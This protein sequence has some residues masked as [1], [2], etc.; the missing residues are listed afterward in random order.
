MLYAYDHHGKLCSLY[1]LSRKQIEQIRRQVTYY[2]PTCKE[3]LQI[4]SGLHHIPHFAHFST[5]QCKRKS[6]GESDE[7]ES[8][9]WLLFKWLKDQGYKVEMEYFIKEINQ[10]PDL[11][12]ISRDKR[13]I[14]IELQCST[15]SPDIIEKRTNSYYEA[16]IFPLWIVGS[17]HFRQKGKHQLLHTTFHRSLL[18]YFHHSYCMYYLNV[19]AQSVIIVDHILG[20][21]HSNCFA[22]S[23]A[24][25]LD[26]IT[27]PQLF[28]PASPSVTSYLYFWEKYLFK[29]RTIYQKSVGTEERQWR[30]FLYLKGKHFS[31][32][33]SVCC[34]PVPSQSIYSVK[35][36][37]WQTKFVLNH[38]ID[39]PVGSLIKLGHRDKCLTINRYQADPVQE[40]LQLLEQM[41]Y[42]RKSPKGN[43]IKRKEIT[44][45][46]HITQALEED[47]L[48]MNV[49]KNMVPRHNN[50]S[51]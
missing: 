50:V 29:L 3:P 48:V 35:V 36:Y 32:I 8:G 46:T 33:P 9:K 47:K 26:S 41:G 39:R 14:A 5:S 24:Y 2:C 42:V 1:Q 20:F 12:F 19:N 4:R 28:A 6:Q 44:F 13:R 7:H 38:F 31:L 21:Q 10:R 27:F 34:L 30:Q 16:G 49:L 43:W 25:L 23:R 17:R 51:L 37:M 18:Y 15:I 40:Y 45:P 11:F 22:R